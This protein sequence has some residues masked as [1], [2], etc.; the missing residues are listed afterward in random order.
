MLAWFGILKAIG[1]YFPFNFPWAF[2]IA[3]GLIAGSI[4]TVILFPILFKVDFVKARWITFFVM[5][6]FIIPLF[7]A[8]P[9][10]SAPQQQKSPLIEALLRIRLP[11]ALAAAVL[12]FAVLMMISMLISTKLYKTREF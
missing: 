5:F 11:Q 4:A 12:V 1:G 8:L 6:I 2:V 9:K 10:P 3:T 7:S